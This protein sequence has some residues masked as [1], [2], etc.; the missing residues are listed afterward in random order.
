MGG[1]LKKCLC[2]ILDLFVLLILIG[3]SLLGG[4]KL[5]LICGEYGR[6]GNRLFFFSHVL[7]WAKENQAVVYYPSFHPYASLFEGTEKDCFV[8]YPPK[9]RRL[10]GNNSCFNRIASNSLHRISL[11]MGQRPQS[12]LIRS[13]VLEENGLDICSENFDL[14]LSRRG[15][16]FIRGFIFTSQKDY[17]I[18]RHRPC[19][20]KIFKPPTRYEKGIQEPFEKLK[21]LCDIVIGIVIR[22][23]DYRE[24][25]AGEYYY[26]LSVFKRILEEFTEHVSPVRPGFFI[27]SDED[28]DIS[29]FEQF[30]HYFRQGHPVENLNALSRCDYLIGSPSTFLTWPSFIGKVP[31]F[32]LFPKDL[33][34][35]RIPFPLRVTPSTEHSSAD[36]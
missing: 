6:L 35:N 14:I 7:A 31:C 29:E 34:K 28:Q 5:Y 2:W 27:A 3:K 23:G 13:I 8:R 17:L 33:N 12:N 9:A 18:E 24:Y 10:L 25:R 1:L 26:P 32:Q 15:L 4:K 20:Q 21:G 30:P 16:L 19:L 22:H 36:N 11:R